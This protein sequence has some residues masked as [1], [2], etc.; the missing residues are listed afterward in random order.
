MNTIRICLVIFLMFNIACLKTKTSNSKK[1]I[2]EGL[3]NQEQ[4]PFY[5]F[6][7]RNLNTNNFLFLDYWPGMSKSDF[8][9]ISDSLKNAMVISKD[10]VGIFTI[11]FNVG[12]D[13]I[14]N[15][16]K[17]TLSLTLN[18]KPIFENDKL[19]QIELFKKKDKKEIG[20]SAEFIT[21]EYFNSLNE[22]FYKKYGTCKIVKSDP[23]R[24]TK[25][26]RPNLTGNREETQWSEYIPSIKRIW[27]TNDKAIIISEEYETEVSIFDGEHSHYLHYYS[28][29]YSTLDYYK[30]KE[31]INNL[32]EI[33]EKT[34]I[35]NKLKESFNR[36]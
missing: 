5:T 6:N 29:T 7:Q 14:F 26:F 24:Y 36:I 27:L 2:A 34:N 9:I 8:N 1:D 11:T 16:T 33:D 23:I 12:E 13:K 4:N 30:S 25:K 32:K 19:T 31:R 18:I 17:Q 15:T 28:I 10:D 21:N 22:L 3:N 35:E 20:I